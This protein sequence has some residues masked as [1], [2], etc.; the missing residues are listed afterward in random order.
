MDIK[1]IWENTQ[2]LNTHQHSVLTIL[3][4]R[5][6]VEPSEG[7]KIAERWLK[8]H[9]QENWGTILRLLKSN[10]LTLVDRELKPISK[11]PTSEPS[12]TVHKYRGVEIE[13]K[14]PQVKVQQT[15]KSSGKKRLY[16][17]VEY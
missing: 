7:I 16:R 14:S 13:N 4:M 6:N 8:D 1:I 11:S 9:S 15:N 12:K 3:L 5:F 10:N 2:M 17:G